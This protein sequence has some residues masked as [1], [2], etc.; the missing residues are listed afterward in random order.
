MVEKLTLRTYVLIDN[1]QPQYAAITGS[2][3]RGDVCLAGMAQLYLEVVPGSSVYGMLDVALKSGGAKPGFQIV[4]R[5]YGEVELHSFDIDDVIYAG[6]S[7]LAAAGL[8]KEDRIS[9]T[10]VSQQIISRVNPYQAQLINR[11]DRYGSILVP[12]ESLLVMEIEPAAYVSLAVNEAEKNADI[13]IITFDVVG[14]YGRMFISGEISQVKSAQGAALAAMR[15][16][17]GGE[18]L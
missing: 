13:K 12:G 7:M 10:V 6:E 17:G 8:T 15:D 5:E 2:L 3:V 1:M 9:P 14:K 11:S 4:E 16:L 18:A